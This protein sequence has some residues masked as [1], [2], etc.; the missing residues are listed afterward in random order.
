MKSTNERSFELKG[1]NK[2]LYDWAIGSKI[3]QKYIEKEQDNIELLFDAFSAN[4]EKRN[5]A[6]EKLYQLIWN[7]YPEFGPNLLIRVLA[8]FEHDR[9]FYRD[10]RNHTSHMI[11]VFFLGIYFYETVKSIHENI[12]KEMNGEENF[13]KVWVLTALYHDIGY[14][15]EN[16]KIEDHEN[17]WNEFRE[18][19]NEMLK[20]PMHYV[21]SDK[22]ASKE[23]ENFF[24]KQNKM[25]RET[26]DTI[27]EIDNK[28]NLVWKILSDVGYTTKLVGNSDKDKNG[29]QIYYNI[30]EKQTGG[31]KRRQ[32]YKDHGICSALI[33]G[34]VWE[35][36]CEVTRQLASCKQHS[37]T[38]MDVDINFFEDL[39]K[40]EDIIKDLVHTAMNAVALHNIDKN[41]LNVAEANGYGI[42]IDNF[43]IDIKKLPIAALLRICDEIQMWDRE[44]FRALNTD[45]KTMFA[46][47]LDIWAKGEAIYICFES[48]K[49]YTDPIG[50][51][52]SMYNNLLGRLRSYLGKSVN[53]LLKYS[54]K[55][56]EPVYDTNKLTDSDNM[57]DGMEVLPKGDQ[58]EEE[59][60]SDR[61]LL[62]AVN[63]DED[64][65]FSALYLG[66][67]MKN[68]LPE[69]FKEFGYEEIIAVYENFNERYY[70][71]EKEC[72]NVANNL[73]STLINDLE[74]WD[75]L[76]RDIKETMEELK[77]I[78]NDEK[79]ENFEKMTDTQI[80]SY[81]RKHY[82]AH[83]QLYTYA[84]I[85]E[86][87]DRGI[88]SFTLFLKQ[89]LKNKDKE[90]ADEKKLNE[91]FE[92]LTYPENINYTG[93]EI[94]DV[95][96]I[97]EK[98]MNT[99]SEEDQKIWKSSTG[100]FLMHLKPD[101]IEII[102]S[103]I[104]TWKYWGY[105]GYRN[106]A[107]IDFSQILER[108]M[109]E[110]DDNTIKERQDR[111]VERQ[112]QAMAKRAKLFSIY[113]IN[114]KYQRL[115]LIYSQMGS[116]K[117]KRRYY[118]LRNFYFLDKLIQEIA[119]RNNV[120]EG[121]IRCMLPDE[122]ISLL[123]GEKEVLQRGKERLA[124]EVFVYQLGKS[125]ESIMCGEE[126]IIL[127]K[128]MKEETSFND[129]VGSELIGETASLGE[130]QGYCWMLNQDN[131]KEFQKGE[132]LVA[133]DL[134]PDKFELLKI[135]GAV[136]TETGGF[137]CHAAIV[138][139]ELHIPCIVGV[140][141]LMDK[142]CTGQKLF[143]D[144][145]HGKI[146]ILYRT[147]DGIIRTHDKDFINKEEMGKKA[148]SLFRLKEAGFE[149]PDFFCIK[150]KEL[151]DIM[152]L[153][154]DGNVQKY[155]SL[156]VGI[157]DALQELNSD[158]LAI[159][160]STNREDG[161]EI[162]GA[163][164]EITM[165]R[166]HCSDVMQDLIHVLKSLEDY[167]GNG[168]I[169]IQKMILG[170][171]S[172]VIFTDNPIQNHN[173]LVIQA[174]PGGNEYL[175]SGKVNPVTFIYDKEKREFSKTKGVWENLLTME[176]C[177]R[178]KDKAMEI[179]A[180]FNAPQDIEWT[181]QEN[182]IFILQS[183]NITGGKKI[184]CNAIFSA[185]KSLDI[186]TISIYQAYALPKHLRDH[187]LRTAALV[188]WILDRWN[189]KDALDK[190]RMIKACLLHDIGNIVKGSDE[191]FRAIFP[192]SFSEDSWQYW[193]NVRAHIGKR[194]G[195]TDIEAT[196][197]IAS[198]INVSADVIKLI[199]EK[200]FSN[201]VKTYNDTDFE[202]KICAYADQRVS[203]DGV[204]SIRDRLSEAKKR[205][206][207]IITSSVNKPNFEELKSCALKI[208]E[209]I[210]AYT[211]GK[212]ED[213]TDASIERYIDQL[214]R[215]RF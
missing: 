100:R 29:I 101:V 76:S 172:G 135:A 41:G 165:L 75:N 90:L 79:C 129:I 204:L 160:S 156:I 71:R 6:S 26:L 122:V 136:I 187:M 19:I 146:Q 50:N 141:G 56:P 138:C 8:D 210:F 109:R 69:E 154:N 93:R 115:F 3:I 74:F 83:K 162:S 208:E 86:T 45:E 63:Q 68:N 61:W 150:I 92:W 66:Q 18:K 166:V 22:G 112:H 65:H 111:L 13:E 105:H 91:V 151:K 9:V 85:P 31:V 95:N 123:N 193:L 43:I 207:G 99:S 212:P 197:K 87:L 157:Q 148:Y 28:D 16:D 194:Y 21:F 182:K 38:F 60:K 80:L 164:Q 64:I 201:N 127:A 211:Q 195:T 153:T 42:N 176:Q 36:Y 167:T 40:K 102:D 114:E 96:E 215:Y 144:A 10:Y 104:N 184:D 142:M 52:K 130:Y 161:E 214:K 178:L 1:V 59:Q 89:Y 39:M 140:H 46:N 47:E 55:K 94:I 35:A 143:V 181:I 149:V 5:N 202:V 132:I 134:D 139:R 103:Y 131:N 107:V 97:S 34:K 98:I 116:L 20:L 57:I 53:D 159:R 175:T 15:F 152:Q 119:L 11:K 155:H 188:C 137:T 32:G 174:V 147:N 133:T 72:I 118:Q 209:Q 37:I 177:E 7:Y 169:I 33:L 58:Q 191:K 51:S 171:Y 158:W 124:S 48:D 126:A 168:C 198:E 121:I 106:R 84:R 49:Q 30:V 205:Q 145:D 213:I 70:I 24:V 62:G 173:E 110:Y 12:D 14:L 183:R 108:L 180:F 4:E 2:T 203:P 67:S 25:Y 81:Y 200:Q 27:A 120:E 179:S 196:L 192:D 44:K 189:G 163:G 206:K 73:I 113:E 199:Q 78:F 54:E 170:S 88:P 82:E 128:K 190:D 117:M 17:E 185:N 77:Q 186:D 23:K 125:G